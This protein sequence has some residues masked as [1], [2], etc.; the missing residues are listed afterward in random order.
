MHQVK[1]FCIQGTLLLMISFTPFP[2][3]FPGTGVIWRIVP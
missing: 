1:D 2:K 3:P